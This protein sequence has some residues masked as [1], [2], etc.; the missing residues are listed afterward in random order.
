[1]QPVGS[2]SLAGQCGQFCTPMD[3]VS[4]N[5]DFDKQKSPAKVPG[6]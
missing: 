2:R 1:M 6:S 3:F 4:F 5:I